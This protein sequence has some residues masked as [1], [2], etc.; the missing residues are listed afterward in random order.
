MKIKGM[1]PNEDL[2]I[3]I[4]PRGRDLVL[5]INSLVDLIGAG[6]AEILYNFGKQLAERYYADMSIPKDLDPDAV[7]KNIL[8]SMMFSGW[9]TK[10][11]IAR[12]DRLVVTLCNVFELDSDEDN[13]NF[14]RGFLAGLSSS[15][16]HKTLMCKE[17]HNPGGVCVF[18]LIERSPS[19]N[20]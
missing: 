17:S 1:E 8:S 16:Y 12:D 9:F 19:K 15:I 3:P 5:L 6:S 10:M 13:C 2:D 18:T 11:E 14:V 4:Y 20:H 7:F